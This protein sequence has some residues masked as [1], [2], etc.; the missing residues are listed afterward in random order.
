MCGDEAKAV[1]ALQKIPYYSKIAPLWISSFPLRWGKLCQQAAGQ[2]QGEWWQHLLPGRAKQPAGAVGQ[3]WGSRAERSRAHPRPA[4]G[5]LAAPAG[6]PWVQAPLA[7]ALPCCI[8]HTFLAEDKNSTIAVVQ[9]PINVGTARQPSD[10]GRAFERA[11]KPV[12]CKQSFESCCLVGNR[13]QAILWWL[14]SCCFILEPLMNLE[15]RRSRNN[16]IDP[17][18]Y[19][20]LGAGC[21][22]LFLSLSFTAQQSKHSTEVRAVIPR[23]NTERMKN[24]LRVVFCARLFIMPGTIFKPGQ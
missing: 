21:A 9:V 19:V 2:G 7:C 24:N 16:E 8:T 14:L 22:A 5:S 1:E 3:R 6:E 13:L 11:P 20:K 15:L 18:L 12:L 4:P 23:S 17:S 10:L